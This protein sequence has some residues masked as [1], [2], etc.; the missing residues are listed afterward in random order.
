MAELNLAAL[1]AEYKKA[2]D[3]KQKED[4]KKKIQQMV[5]SQ[6]PEEAMASLKS[7]DNRISE[8]KEGIELGEIADMA[9][10]SYIAEKY[11]KKTRTWLYQRLNGNIVNG[12]PAQFTKEEKETFAKALQDMSKKFH[13][14]SLSIMNG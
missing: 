14:K 2:T 12:K 6:S 3:P 5:A 13:E 1:R 9:S 11:F 8:I 4:F 7:I 10:M